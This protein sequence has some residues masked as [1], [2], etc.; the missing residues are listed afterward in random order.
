MI[1]QLFALAFLAVSASASEPASAPS[2]GKVLVVLNSRNDMNL[3]ARLAKEGVRLALKKNSRALKRAPLEFVF[4]DFDDNVAIAADQIKAAVDQHHPIAIVGTIRSDH[5]LV[6]ADIAER[7][8][9]PFVTPLS[10][11]PKVTEGKKFTLRTCFDDRTQADLLSQFVFREKKHTRV[12][13]LFNQSQVFSHGFAIEFEKAARKLGVVNILSRPLS[14]N[15]EV[16]SKTTSELQAFSPDAVLVP[17]YQ[18]EAAAVLA[19]LIAV[20]P[21]KVEFFGPDSWGGGRLFH[22]V[23]SGERNAVFRGFYAEHWSREI[24]SKANRDFLDLY[25]KN[26]TEV[27]GL[28]VGETSDMAPVAAFYEASDFLIQAWAKNHRAPLPRPTFI[29]SL[30]GFSYEGPRGRVSF[31]ENASPKPLYI[32]GIGA[33]TERFLGSFSNE[34]LGKP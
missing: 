34:G 32:F 3:T 10:T 11:N 7:M 15:S 22:A 14:E 5:A 33:G 20:L 29:A 4:S 25:L 18:V 19:K 23:F 26:P 21:A 6:A 16:D 17:S 9:I 24:K 12:A 13:I 8:A 27:K 30:R 2:V 31:G 1:R 28:R